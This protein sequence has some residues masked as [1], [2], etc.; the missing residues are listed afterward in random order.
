MRRELIIR[1]NLKIHMNLV[2]SLLAMV[3]FKFAQDYVY[4]NELT[5]QFQESNSILH[6]NPVSRTIFLLFI[7]CIYVMMYSKTMRDYG[8]E[9]SQFV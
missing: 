6:K 4:Y 5:Y 7:T 2:V 8:G 1:D 3:V 9:V